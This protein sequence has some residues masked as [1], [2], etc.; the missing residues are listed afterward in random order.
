MQPVKIRRSGEEKPLISAKIKD[1]TGTIPISLW[2]KTA[3]Q[4]QNLKVGDCV[5]IE[6]AE[7]GV[8]N[9]KATLNTWEDSTTIEVSI[10]YPSK[11]ETQQ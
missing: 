9:S 10:I 11:K 2:G 4:L 7:R 1:K 3:T 8:F 6:R 5:S